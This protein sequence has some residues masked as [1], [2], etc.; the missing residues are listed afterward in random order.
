M[1]VGEGEDAKWKGCKAVPR[2]A[3]ACEARSEVGEAIRK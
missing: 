3:E 2:E 1:E